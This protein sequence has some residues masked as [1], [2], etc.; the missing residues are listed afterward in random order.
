MPTASAKVIIDAEDL[1]SKKIA[2]AAR[3]IEANVKHITDVGGKAKAST[4]FFGALANTL[5]DSQLAR[6]SSELGQLTE[7]VSQFSEVSK[8]GSAGTL[9][10]KAGL[11]GLVA[12]LSFKVGESIGKVIFK[13]EQWRKELEKATEQAKKLGEEV[14]DAARSGASSKTLE[15]LDKDIDA[16][17]QQ[18]AS[19]RKQVEAVDETWS[20]FFSKFS[21]NVKA[22][23]EENKRQI[24]EAE[25]LKEIFKEQ[26]LELRRKTEADKEA[27]AVAEKAKAEAEAIDKIR[28]QEEALAAAREAKES[29]AARAAQQRVDEAKRV[30]D[31]RQ[32][33]IERLIE[34][35]I[36]LTEG[37][38]AAKRY[39]LE[40]QGV[41]ALSAER[42]AAAQKE[43]EDLK[44]KS[45]QSSNIPIGQQA[46][47]SRLLTR[48]PAEQ[49]IDKIEKNTAGALQKFDRLIQQLEKYKQPT[50]VEIVG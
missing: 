20:G 17:N 10:L 32:R 29:E 49:G 5:G 36:L 8:A 27:L 47:Q 7:K 41:D 1:A 11:V 4:E 48:G 12:V 46:V 14:I 31:I 42:I 22:Y 43:V 45:D 33:E 9:A 19:Y 3:K 21:G 38:E 26:A 18:I 35:K 15:Q 24:T 50:A 25:R 6:Y 34:E 16:K 44:E 30:D 28:A 23:H 39:A 40:K 13:T 2:D 37:A